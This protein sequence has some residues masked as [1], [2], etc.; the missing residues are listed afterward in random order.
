MACKILLSLFQFVSQSVF[1]TFYVGS[2][3]IE[4]CCENLINDNDIWNLNSFH[5]VQ[6]INEVYECCESWIQL[7]ESLTKLFWPN[8]IQHQWIGEPHI[9]M[10]AI[11][12]RERL[13]EIKNI[14]NM[15]KQIASIFLENNNQL[16]SQ[17][18]GKVFRPFRGKW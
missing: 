16:L 7:C 12:F 9:P 18:I 6:T 2:S 4:I 17:N 5:I 13:N 1:I 11:Q 15:Y 14:K 10:Q 3:I 8:N